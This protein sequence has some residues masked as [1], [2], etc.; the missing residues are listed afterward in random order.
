M[1][2]NSP[3]SSESDNRVEERK[4]KN[5]LRDKRS[6]IFFENRQHTLSL[7]SLTYSE[8]M[9]SEQVWTTNFHFPQYWLFTSSGTQKT[10]I[11]ETVKRNAFFDL[12]IS[13][14]KIR[15]LVSRVN[16]NNNN[17]K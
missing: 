2:A 8:R 12:C 14:Y 16:N 13:F 9:V 17:N 4:E 5:D 3:A 6:F 7:L 11:M 10:S 15:K 1:L